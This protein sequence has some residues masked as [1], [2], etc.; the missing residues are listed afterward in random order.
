MF[1]SSKRLSVAALA[2]L[3]AILFAQLPPAAEAAAATSKTGALSYTFPVGAASLKGTGSVK[4][5]SFTVPDYWSVNQA[6]LH[7]IYQAT[8]LLDESRSSITLSLNGTSF[9]SFR[10]AAGTSSK[11]QLNV[12]VP[13]GLISKGSNVL[14][15]ES[16]IRTEADDRCTPD[17]YSENWLE[18][19]DNSSLTFSYGWSLEDQSVSAFYGFMTGLDVTEENKGAVAVPDQSDANELEAAVQALSGLVKGSDASEELIPMLPLG[20]DAL[21]ARK[22]VVAV[23]MLD[24]LPQ[25]LRSL[26]S[27]T[28]LS[29]Q[30]LIELVQW[31]GRP[32]LV[33]TSANGELLVK[34]A[35]FIANEELVKQVSASSVLVNEATYVDTPAFSLSQNVSLTETGDKLTGQE[36]QEQSY[37]IALPAN[38]SIADSSKLDLHFRY[39][40]NVDFDKSMVSVLVDGTPIGS[41]KLSSEL[42]DGDELTLTLP[43]NLNISGNFSVTVA[44][45]LYMASEYCTPE[46]TQ[47]PWAYI[48]SDSLLQLNTK[49]RTELLFNNYP[50]PFIRDGAY[51]Q[52]AVVMPHEIKGYTYRT[53]SSLFNLL[54]RYAEGNTGSVVFLEDTATA[55][56]LKAYNLIVIGSYTSNQV[57]QA[58]NDKLYFRYDSQGEGFVSN[59]KMSIEQE[60]GKRIGS[61]QLLESPYDSSRGMLAVTGVEPQLIYMASELLGSESGLWN[62]YGDGVVTDMDGNIQS[63][64]FKVDADAEPSGGGIAELTE[65]TDVLTFLVSA[66]AILVIVL[67][68]LILL[69]RKYRRRRGDES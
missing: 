67:L 68:S 60:Y 36:H 46:Y 3:I 15:I 45:D 52:I 14:T 40:R 33:V 29:E 64:R 63:Y 30:A 61:L 4:S 2:I 12:A 5:V 54:G 9:Y 20:S 18:L 43:K 19:Y 44:F 23:A 11:Q 24:H 42:A 34:A 47:A 49:D 37:Y 51:N 26:L 6:A 66:A 1:N 31:D 13:G 25:D 57:I 8:P 32:T 50:Y 69:L 35:R 22:A 48:A 28:E 10:P 21:A 27:T 65:R 39:A 53:V 38:R 55:D 16:D 17:D 41:K 58:N 62:V 7:L 59:E 56:E